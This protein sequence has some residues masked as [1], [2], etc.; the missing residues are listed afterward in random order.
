MTVTVQ[1][2]PNEDIGL[3]PHHFIGLST[4]AKPTVASHSGLPSPTNGSTFWEYD[5]GDTYKTHDGTNWSFFKEA[6]RGAGLVQIK[7]VTVTSA[8]NAGDV[9]LATVTTQ[10]CEI[11]SVVVQSNGATTA[12]LTNVAVYGGAGKVVTFIGAA[13]GVR[14]NIDAADK[15]VATLG[16]VAL[17][18]TKTVVMT[19]TGAGVTAVDL[20]VIIA[21][22]ALADGGYLV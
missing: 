3:A 17:A 2:N 4:D 10:A 6:S 20:T 5:T 1:T 13:Q 11:E 14:A 9:T 22:R 19:L 16:P 12:D 21:Y 15:Q 7:S 8:A 18:A